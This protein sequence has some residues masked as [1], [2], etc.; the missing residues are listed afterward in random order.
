MKRINH[1]EPRGEIT[2]D[3]RLKGNDAL[4]GY[5]VPV[6][7]LILLLSRICSAQEFTIV[8]TL[9]DEAQGTT[10]A[11]DGLAFVTGNLGADSFFPPGKVADFWGFQYLRDNDPS[12]MGHNTDFLTRASL[13]ML[14]VLTPSQRQ[15]LITLANSQVSLIN[16]YG[17]NRFVLMKAFRRLLTGDVP[18][19]S[20]GLDRNAVR[21]YS[22]ELYQLDGSMS[23][24]RA[25]VMGTMLHVLTVPQKAHLDSMVGKGMLTW[26]VVGEP[27]E[28]Q[29]IS[30]NDVK[31]AVMTYAG[32]MFSWYAGSVDADVYFCPERQGTYFGSFYMKDAPAVGNPNYS[33]DTNL[34]AVYGRKFLRTLTPPESLMISNLVDLQRPYL[35]EIVD[36]RKDISTELR[37]F[38]IGETPDSGLV[39]TLMDRYGELDGEIVYRIATNFAA[40]N[41]MINSIQRDTLMAFRQ[42]VL[43]SFLY[44]A[45]AYLYASPIPVP[46][47]Q[48]TDFLFTTTSALTYPI[49]GTDVTSCYDNTTTIACPTSA[50]AAF[51]GQSHGVNLPSYKNNGNGTITDL[52]TGLTWQSSPDANGNSNGTIEKADKLTWAQIQARVPVLNSS[53]YGGYS[54]WRIPTIKELY[55][56][57]NWNGTDPSAYTGTGTTGLTPFIDNTYFPFAWGQT[58]AGERLIDVQYASSNM[59]NELSFAGYQQLFGFN[60]ADGRIKGYDLVM[61]GG[62][63]K[64]FS[65]IAVRGNTAYGI[66]NFVDNGDST[67]SDNATGLMWTKFDSRTGM[68]WQAALAWAQT[69]NAAKYCGYTDWRLP[70][71]KELQSIVDY[72]RSPGSTNSAAINPRFDCTSIINEAGYLDWPWFWTSTTHRSY[73]GT[74]YGGANGI[75]VCF[76]RAAGWVKIGTNSYYSY[77]DVHGAG[78]QRSSPKSGTYVGDYYGVDSLGH[79][80][81]G[82]GPQGD[83]LRINNFVRLVRDLATTPQF[84]SGSVHGTLFYDENQNGSQDANERGLEGWRVYLSGASSDSAVTDAHGSYSFVR[85]DSGMYHLRAESRDGWTRTSPVPSDTTL[86]VANNSQSVNF[87][88]Y[89][90]SVHVCRPAERW[91]LLSLPVT[92]LD[93]TKRSLFPNAA[94][95][96]YAYDESYVQKDTLGCGF[97]FWL[98]FSQSCTIYIA[99]APAHTE[100]LAVKSGW[101]LIGSISDPLPVTSITSE[102]GGIV[103]GNFFGYNGSYFRSDTIVPGKGYW[104]KVGQAGSLILSASGQINPA[105]RI[106]IVPASELPPSP[107]DD[108]TSGQNPIPTEY[109]LD[110]AYPSPFNPTT[111]IRYQLPADSRVSLKV[112]NMLGQVVAVLAD[113][114]QSAGYKSVEWHAGGFASGV[115][116]YRL[117]AVHIADPSK[118]FTQVKKVMLVR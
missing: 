41:G 13:N 105:N 44:P 89:S 21:A 96:A 78:A 70:N 37:K 2:M 43:G 98:R 24:Q 50:G 68:N 66:N 47:I 52:N 20:T 92:P 103:S 106:K 79:P 28:F 36:R 7:L 83:I 6:A 74:T 85:I 25:R 95:S 100:T 118:S 55:S 109:A 16:Q 57:T 58:S 29:S 4:L 11:F 17:Y 115:Y 108:V 10:I 114:Q 67:I 76:G 62:S 51:Y 49:V 73:N 104:V 19:G 5:Y 59:Y 38:M 1:Q 102:P 69:K 32:D 111:T 40:V 71:A 116:F 23:F 81:Y 9:S 97:G 42:Q 46:A 65:F 75:Y 39:M 18:P 101:N 15:D 30:N 72:T 113:E 3:M 26:P 35:Y 61:P 86:R 107:P 45:G 94:S 31:V 63:S 27:P 53:H 60:F 90:P 99:G 34:T 84:D 91:N 112:H 117:E 8:Q 22:T 64:V 82:L 14:Y 88:M 87:G 33:I 12:R 80:V 110:N 77:R 54:D 48:S 56:L 93:K